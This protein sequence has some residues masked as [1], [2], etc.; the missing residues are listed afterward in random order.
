MTFR[1]KADTELLKAECYR[2]LVICKT[3]KVG[4]D[5]EQAKKGILTKYNIVGN[6]KTLS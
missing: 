4:C 5:D 2:A 6:I 3:S 1:M